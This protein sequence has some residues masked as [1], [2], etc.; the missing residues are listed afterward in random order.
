MEK[1]DTFAESLSLQDIL[2]EYGHLSPETTRRFW[3]VSA[4]KPDEFVEI[5]VGF[6]EGG[7]D[8]RNVRFLWDL[9]RWAGRKW[10]GFCHLPRSFQIMATLLIRARMLRDAECLLLSDEARGVFCGDGWMFDE[11]VRGYAEDS[12]LKNAIALYDKVRERGLVLSASCYKTLLDLLIRMEKAELATRVYVDMIE[13][14]LGSCS[15][16]CCLEFVVGALCRKGRTLE[17]VNII[18]KLK[19]FDV[20]PSPGALTAIVEGYCRKK[21]YEDSLKFMR[22]WNHTPEARTC[23]KLTSSWCRNL[24]IEEAWL[25][26]E[27]LQAMG[28]ELD[29]TTFGILISQCCSEQ[30]L[31]YAFIYLSESC[32]RGIKLEVHAY[33]A[34]ISRLFMEGMFSSAR[35][36]FEEMIEKGLVPGLSTFKVLLAG[37]CKHRKFDE[38]K[39]VLGE[40]VKYGMTSLAPTEDALSKAFQ[41]LGLDC[42]RVKVKRDNDLGLAK[43]EFFDSL[44]NGL[45]LETDVEEYDKALKEILNNGIVP[46]FDSM[47]LEKC[48]KGDIV[49]A[50]RV[51]HE[52]V[53]WGKGLSVST[54][55]KLIECLCLSSSYIKTTINLLDG[56]PQLLD[57]LDHKT[58]NLLIQY[59]SKNGVTIRARLILDVLLKKQMVIESD[60]Y[61]ALLLGFCKD[62]N[63]DEVRECLHLVRRSTWLRGLMDIKELISFLCEVGMIKEVLVLI[64]I[65]TVKHPNHHLVSGICIA[66]TKEMCTRGFTDVGHILVEEFLHRGHAANNA[67][68]LSIIEGFIK[69]KKFTKALGVIDQLRG[70]NITLSTSVYQL[71]APLLFNFKGAEKST[72]LKEDMLIAQSKPASLVHSTLVNEYCK[73]GKMREATFQLNEMLRNKVFPDNNTLNALIQG[74]CHVKSLRKALEILSVM[75]RNDIDLSISG[76]RSLIRHFCVLGQVFSAFGLKELVRVKDESQSLIL[77]NILIFCLFQTGNSLLVEAPLKKMLEKQL[78]PS[79]DTY[80]ILIYG[81]NK[82]G[83]ITRSVKLLNNMITEGMKPN[84][85]SLRTIIC[86]LCS[87]GELS[88]ALELS[89]VMERNGWQHGSVILH[90]LT[91]GLLQRGEIFMAECFIDQIKENNLIPDN[92]DFDLLIKKFCSHGRIKK[93]VDLLTLMLK[94]GSI[95]SDISYSLVIK[96]LSIQKMFDQALDFHAE[97][98]YKTLNPSLDSCNTLVCG[99]CDNDRTDDA[100]KVLGEMLRFGPVPTKDMYKYV[101]DKYYAQNNLNMASELLQEMQQAGY[102]P[103]FETY[104]SL[105]SNLSC[106]DKKYEDDDGDDDAIDGDGNGFLSHLLSGNGQPVKNYG[107][108]ILSTVK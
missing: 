52:A 91:E 101:I 28:F 20:E 93:A 100:R 32:S 63:I 43:A 106:R 74:Y 54:Y 99:L 75:L 86:Y 34:L 9:F 27:R 103:N 79:Q 6:G 92:V 102:S 61:T 90:A 62:K 37:Y 104:W 10:R 13:D 19:G 14:G 42:L 96:G 107:S 12:Q 73:M 5:L 58:L 80:N 41:I 21:D 44:G 108:K 64:D 51:N 97:M 77:D 98:L 67:S 39:Q 8:L 57:L 95:P 60:A 84:N 35:N 85:R 72:S 50:I 53:Q 24:G 68:C 25:S 33:D 78:V 17:A 71:I 48:C 30:K 18:R 55:S 76:Y 31:R 3:R 69:E 49:A 11:I 87:N 40:M 46:D 47:V 66:I 94:K 56:T 15:E 2:K 4:L 22:E 16:D 82:C 89:K 88:K 26:V 105:V 45:Y 36:I 83:D 65:I 23:N 38:V 70:K 7:E 29:A 1:V 59:L 81:F